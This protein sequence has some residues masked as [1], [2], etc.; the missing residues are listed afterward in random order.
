MEAVGIHAIAPRHRRAHIASMRITSRRRINA[1]LHAEQTELGKR[2]R[3]ELLIRHDLHTRRMIQCQQS[4]LIEVRNLSQLLGH[5]DLVL[6]IAHLQGIARD[7][8]VLVVVH[9]EIPAVA[10]T[11]AE[12]RHAQYIGNKLKAL[13]VPC[14]DHRTRTRKPRGLLDVHHSIHRHARLILY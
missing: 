1:L 9:R 13:P 4:N 5:A 12:R 3:L 10:R 11:R 6:A 14:E 8:H 2:R 7:R